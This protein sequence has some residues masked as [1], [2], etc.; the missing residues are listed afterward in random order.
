MTIKKFYIEYDAINSR[1]TFTN[2]DTINGRIILET[3]KTA[4]VQSIGFQAKGKARVRW[5]EYHGQHD[6]RVYWA[7]EKY[8]SIKHDILR[9]ARQIGSEIVGKGRHVFPFSFKIPNRQMPSTFHSSIG[10]VVHKMKAELKQ[11]MK[12]TKKSECPFIFV[13]KTDMNMPGLMVPQHG[14]KD[15]SLAFGSG[16]ISLDASIKKTGYIPGEPINVSIEI[17]N[18][19][20]R[21]VKPKFELYEKRS[22]F[23]QGRRK[24]ETNKL[25]KGKDNDVDS[26]S[27]KKTV[28]MTIPVPALLPS[29]LNCSIIKV[30]YRLKIYLEVKCA[31]NPQVKFPIVILQDKR[32]E[33][34]LPPLDTFGSEAFGNTNHPT[35]STTPQAM[36]PPPSYEESA[37]H[38]PIPPAEFKTAL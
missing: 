38:P 5:S 8:Y 25:L 2:G 28:T 1:N 9:E 27:G 29:M 18:R 7:K 6:H 35:W 33:R 13:S 36:D 34:Q 20:S 15:K 24:L 37:M 26:F 4:K 16:N 32:A 21:S 14:S 11:S 17:N 23:A 31:A 19:S 30:E 3:T 12:L 10:R 22:F